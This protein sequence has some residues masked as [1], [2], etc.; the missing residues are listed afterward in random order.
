MVTGIHLQLKPFKRESNME[1]TIL[2]CDE[3][4]CEIENNEFIIIKHMD[5]VTTEVHK[6][7]LGYVDI[8]I[9]PFDT[10]HFC[11]KDCMEQ[12]F[13]NLARDAWDM[14]FPIK[15]KYTREVCD[16]KGPEGKGY[17]EGCAR[18]TEEPR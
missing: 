18:K 2:I 13:R 10:M 8:K 14:K 11:S 1:K 16:Y 5:K 4:E 15:C 6:D 7:S 9:K 17:C 3:C 12:Y